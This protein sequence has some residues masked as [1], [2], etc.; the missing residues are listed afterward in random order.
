[1]KT[2]LEVTNVRLSGKQRPATEGYRPTSSIGG[3]KFLCNFDSL[4]PNPLLPSDCGAVTVR[5]LLE[6]L[7]KELLAIG[8][9]IQ[10]YEGEKLVG[11]GV[12]GRIIE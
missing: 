7:D 12:I 8:K 4:V 6:D 3:R 1:M 9:V 11:D 10:F 2:I 5:L